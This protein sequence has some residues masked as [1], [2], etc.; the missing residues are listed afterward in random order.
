VLFAPPRFVLAMIEVRKMALS[1][2][3]EWLDNESGRSLI[4]A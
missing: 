1:K 3:E 2:L 4:Y